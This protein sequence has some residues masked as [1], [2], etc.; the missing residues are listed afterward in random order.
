[1]KAF[2]AK[3]SVGEYISA[4]VAVAMVVFLI[5]YAVYS[6][7]LSA[8]NSKI[9]LYMVAI[10]AINAAYFFVD[11]EMPVDILGILEIVST[12]VTALCAVSFLKDTFNSLA[13]LLNGIALFSGGTGNVTVIF[14]VLGALL[15]MGVLE[16]VV[17]FMKKG[18]ATA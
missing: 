9:L 16:I 11:L 3:K 6:S 5:V 4:V 13:D 17:C 1:M 7:G 12:I 14:T 8:L 10:I 15:V 18:K 2:L